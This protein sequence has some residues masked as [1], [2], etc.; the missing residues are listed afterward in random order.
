MVSLFLFHGGWHLL[1]PDRR[2]APGGLFADARSIDPGMTTR[3]YT[4][5]AVIGGIYASSVQYDIKLNKDGT[6]YHRYDQSGAHV[7]DT[8]GAQPGDV[9]MDILHEE[10]CQVSIAESPSML[11][12]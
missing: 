10:G 4:G 12:Q 7:G 9:G 8:M 1:C 2:S 11:K 3:D 6:L 5:Y